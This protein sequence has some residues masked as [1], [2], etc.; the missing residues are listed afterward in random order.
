MVQQR[1]DALLSK[2]LIVIAVVYPNGILSFIG[3]F[4]IHIIRD[5]SARA[6]QTRRKIDGH[7]ARYVVQLQV[8]VN[9][10]HALLALDSFAEIGLEIL[11]DK[12]LMK[13]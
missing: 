10:V 3:L 7:I 9:N 1:N 4:L 5:D 6:G 8:L 12:S 13:L 2:K 11:V